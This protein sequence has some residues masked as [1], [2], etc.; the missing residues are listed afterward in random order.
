MLDIR[1]PCKISSR[2]LDAFLIYHGRICHKR[3][4]TYAEYISLVA[5]SIGIADLPDYCW[6][7]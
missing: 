6:K 2:D 7:Q 3:A 1:Q 4:V 5:K